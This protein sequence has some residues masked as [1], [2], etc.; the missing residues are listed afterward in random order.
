MDVNDIFTQIGNFWDRIS[1]P[2]LFHIIFFFL[3]IFIF[4]KV[5]I[6]TAIE[7]YIQSNG[8]NRTKAI[9]TEFELWKKLPLILIVFVL[10]YLTLFNSIVSII[11]SIRVFPFNVAYS[12]QDFIKEYEPK[13]YIIEIAKYGKDTLPDLFKVDQLKEKLIEDYK[14]KYPDKYD[15][16][17]K[18]SND[19]FGDRIRTFNLTALTIVS[20]FV[21]LIIRI[22]QKG[23][24]GK[25][26]SFFKFIL[27]LI[28]AFPILFLFRY[29]AEQSIE[30]T[31]SNEIMFVKSTLE[32]DTSRQMVLDLAQTSILEKRLIQELKNGKI[33]QPQIW[34][35]RIVGQS[36]VLQSLLGHRKLRNIVS[37]NDNYSQ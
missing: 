11:G 10:I 2:I 4:G 20:L 26:A 29:R 15:T 7:N 19:K 17:V 23:R 35:S 6:K 30:E 33:H 18:W 16:W 5:S 9:L 32:I 37:R 24:R 34:V 13:D 31:F 25:I 27:I 3:F 1:V 12:K 21:I 22:F 28:I 8:F 14:G 36:E